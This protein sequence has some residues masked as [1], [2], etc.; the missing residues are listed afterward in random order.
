MSEKP[1][2]AGGAYNSFHWV[3]LPTSTRHPHVQVGEEGYP[4]RL[5]PLLPQ[6]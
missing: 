6:E 5:D 1:E 3:Y 2:G 4:R